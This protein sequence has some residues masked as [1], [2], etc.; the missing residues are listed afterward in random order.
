MTSTPLIGDEL[1]ARARA[2]HFRAKGVV[3]SLRSGLHKSAHH[4]ASMVFAEHREYRPGDDPRR[5]DWRAYARSGK[6]VIRRFEQEAQLRAQLVQDR[7]ASMNWNGF[8]GEGPTKREYAAILLASIA[9]LLQGQGDAIGSRYLHSRGGLKPSARRSQLLSILRQLSDPAEGEDT[10]SLAASL[11]S[12]ASSTPRRSL[13]VIASDFLH[14]DEDLAAMPW[15][16][17]S[18]KG[19]EVI[20]FHVLHADEVA[21]PRELSARFFGLEDEGEIEADMSRVGE[22]YQDAMNQFRKEIQT[23]CAQASIRY[24]DARMDRP[25]SEVLAAGLWGAR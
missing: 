9:H 22:R 18:A 13:L 11:A 6:P 19:R 8:A 15:N 16:M 21:P 1:A 10:L 12:I 5:L 23:R 14:V 25:V 24:V 4:G 2:L 7:S 3:E 17:L 20:V